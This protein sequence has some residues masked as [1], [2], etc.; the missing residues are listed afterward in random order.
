MPNVDM[1]DAFFN[2]VYEVIR[3]NKDAIILTADHD[4]F[5]LSKIEKEFPKQFFNVGIS[6]QNMISVAAGLAKSGKIVYVYSINNFITLRSLE[7]VNV[8]LCQMNLNVNLIGVGAG[9]TYSTDGP[10]HQG[11]Q[12][13]QVMRV[14]PN[15]EVYNV[16]D[17]TNSYEMAKNSYRKN[18]PKYFRIEKGLFDKI[19]DTYDFNSG[20]NKI[21][22]ASDTYIVATGFMVHTALDV[23]KK[24]GDIGVIDV[25]KIK[26]FDENLFL[27]HIKN[28][29]S[30]ITLEEN[31]MSGG[32]GEKIGFI[33]AKNNVNCNFTPIA[34][35]NQHCFNYGNRELL[36]K[37]YKIDFNSVL[38]KINEKAF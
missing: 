34:V 15:L 16:T 20:I 14:L 27:E 32:I 19:Y 6:E 31:T 26:P 8:D 38:K 9:F 11:M 22:N 29:K 18:C 24:I 1:R 7:Q 28:V 35:E 5:G 33:L 2:G 13:M 37:K 17:S 4:A 23:S 3:D 10:T 21:V 25:T 36:H 12:D 30:I